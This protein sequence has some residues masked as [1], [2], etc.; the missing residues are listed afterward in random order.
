MPN[1][2]GNFIKSLFGR[3]DAAA[4]DSLA[5]SPT[6]G[7]TAPEVWLHPDSEELKKQTLLQARKIEQPVF[8][9]GRRVSDSVHYPHDDPPDLLLVENPP[10]TLSRS[11]CAIEVSQDKVIL[12][13][14]G[15]RAG[16][17]LGKKRLRKSG[18]KPSSVVVPKG[19][20]SLILGL[21]DGPFRF[22]LEVR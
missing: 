19:S 16:T 18:R 7:Y 1:V 17:M 13:D 4:I 21:R 12:R 20:H 14:L 11:Q 15:S 6:G 5:P 9:I 2:V 10:Y 22:R 8:S 3:K